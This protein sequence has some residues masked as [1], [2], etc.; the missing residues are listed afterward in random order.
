[1]FDKEIEAIA[2][3]TELI[4]DLDDNAKVRVM[5][6]LIERFG[7]GFPKQQDFIQ[8]SDGN[9]SEPKQINGRSQSNEDEYIEVEKD[10]SYPTLKD[11]MI[12]NYP[13]SE[14]EW[15]LC[16]AFY[17]SAFG[18]D[19]FSKEDM[20]EKYRLHNRFTENNQK[21]FASNLNACI[22]KRLD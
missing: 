5:K 17:C 10:A 19:T 15:I 14:A 2:K 13:K 16:Y 7:I 11:L 8:Q 1:M 3:C 6:Y 22:K 9:I 4:K 20:I 21:N 18:T 12:K